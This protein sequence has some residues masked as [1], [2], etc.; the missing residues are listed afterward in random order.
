M[1]VPMTILVAVAVRRLEILPFWFEVNG[2]LRALDTTFIQQRPCSCH[3]V[4]S[5]AE[6]TDFCCQYSLL[7]VKNFVAVSLTPVNS[8]SVYQWCRWHRWTIFHPCQ[9]HWWWHFPQ[10]HWYRSEITKK[11]KITGVNVTAGKLFTGVN[12]TNDKFFT[13]TISTCLHLKMKNS[14]FRCKVHPPKL[15]TK[16]EK[17]TSK[18]LSFFAGVNDSTDKH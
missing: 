4:F 5:F 2:T 9:R 6:R 8:L 10:C 7:Q 3:A 12:D 18:F 17:Y 1:A 13:N 14:I 11:P 16:Y 15:L